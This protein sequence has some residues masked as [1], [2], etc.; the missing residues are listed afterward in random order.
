MLT[1]QKAILGGRPVRGKRGI[2]AFDAAVPFG[3]I[4]VEVV[5]TLNSL[6]AT[7]PTVE[8]KLP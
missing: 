4:P 8:E 1:K 7:N 2:A 5:G 3:T 6:G